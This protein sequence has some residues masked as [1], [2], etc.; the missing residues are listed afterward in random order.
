MIVIA[1]SSPFI[2]L[3]A[4][5]QSDFWISHKLLDQRLT[6]FLKNRPPAS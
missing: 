1:D 5:K 2:A 3:T 4:I 6:L